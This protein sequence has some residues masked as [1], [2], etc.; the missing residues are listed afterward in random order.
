[1]G[2]L[3][4]LDSPLMRALTRIADIMILNLLTIL[5]ALPLVFEQVLLLYPVYE[6]LMSATDIAQ[7][8]SYTGLIIIA[9]IGGIICSIPLGAA[10]TGMHYVLLKMVRDEDSYIVKSFFKSFKEN[11]KQATV[12]QI[13]KFGIAGILFLDF[14]IMLGRNTIYGYIVLAFALILYMASLYTFPLLSKFVN[15][16]PGTIKN[17]FLMAVLALPKT[18]LMAFA[19]AIPIIVLYFFDLRAVPVMILIGIAGPAYL[20]ALLYNNTFKRFE[21]KEEEISEEEELNRAI[22]KIDEDSTVE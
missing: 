15:T 9:W 6:A 20:E 4:D 5:F 21:P 8:K 18:V 16:V 10:C 22:Q 7:L 11:F 17:S 2:K 12:L 3:F 1:M 19:T 14:I 13:I